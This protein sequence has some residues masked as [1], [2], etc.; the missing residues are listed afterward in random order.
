MSD[1]CWWNCWQSGRSLARQRLDYR[2]Y[3]NRSIA[4]APKI[5][6]ITGV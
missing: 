3:L 2:E 4:I 1:W 5:N 6:R